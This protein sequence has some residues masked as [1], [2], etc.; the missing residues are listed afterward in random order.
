MKRLVL[1]C[2]AVLTLWTARAEVPGFTWT[3]GTD[4][5]ST[6]LW[7]GLNLGGLSAQPD[8]MIG[9]GG[10]ELEAWA[11]LGVQNYDF[12]NFKT[13]N[14]FI[15]E[16]DLTLGY[17]I[18]GL[19][20]G[21]THYHYFDG[22]KY[23]DLKNYDYNAYRADDY[24]TDQL[25]VFLT[26]DLGEVLENIPLKFGWYTFVAG[27][28]KYFVDADGNYVSSDD[29]QSVIDD[30]GYSLK[31]AFSTYIELGYDIN[32]PLGISLTP[33]IG[34]TPW[35][36]QYTFY[37]GKFA[38]NN[39]SLKFNWEYEAGDHFCLDLYAMAMLNTYGINKNNVFTSFKDM[40]D[41]RLNGVIGIGL[42]F[43]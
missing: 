2:V 24:S 14:A 12:K 4:L 28:D 3:V 16:L 41:Q 35:R 10:L 36:S 9:F 34:M 38:V 1:L 43:Y 31:R 23:F 25:E 21:A 20:V 8:V 40:A 26:Y 27:D 39:V 11:N 7:R 32:L 13:N 6:Y 17:H 19:K 42:W 15:P 30:S 5:V 22:S 18:F 29:M 33:T 37:D